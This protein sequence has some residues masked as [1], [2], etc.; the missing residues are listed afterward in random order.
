[1]ILSQ[2][3]VFFQQHPQPVC[4]CRV[5]TVQAALESDTRTLAWEALW[6]PEV[7]KLRIGRRPSQDLCGDINMGVWGCW[8][9]GLSPF[10][11]W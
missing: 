5:G 2:G 9:F 3:R 11:G 1:M 7:P 4:S 6:G 8:T 10:V